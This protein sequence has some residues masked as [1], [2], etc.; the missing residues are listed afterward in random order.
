[1][2]TNSHNPTNT[3]ISSPA[4]RLPGKRGLSIFIRESQGDSFRKAFSLSILKTDAGIMV[5]P[6]MDPWGDITCSQLTVPDSGGLKV[7]AGSSMVVNSD[8][9]PKLHYHRSGF[10][11]VQPA[12]R[13]ERKI[14]RLPSIDSVDRVQIFDA[15][16]RVPTKLPVAEEASRGIFL[17]TDVASVRTVGISGVLYRRDLLESNQLERLTSGHPLIQS[18]SI[19]SAVILDLSGYG[20]NTLLCL[21]AIFSP[22]PLPD[23]ASDFTLTSFFAP[24]IHDSG[25]VSIHAGSGE[26]CPGLMHAPPP[27]SAVLPNQPTSTDESPLSRITRIAT[28]SEDTG[29]RWRDGATDLSDPIDGILRP[30]P[31]ERE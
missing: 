20:S 12:G 21:F 25:G 27:I 13:T 3:G 10:T 16:M 26:P 5:T 28:Q 6:M 29:R 17:A 2:Q 24:S 15:T 18:P 23:F 4:Q 19:D 31:R 11:S 30:M 8:N 1:M 14:A 9:R 7:V 22:T